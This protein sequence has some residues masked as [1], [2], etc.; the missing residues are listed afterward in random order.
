VLLALALGNKGYVGTGIGKPKQISGS[1]IPNIDTWQKKSRLQRKSAVWCC[2]CQ[3]RYEGIIG[4]G[5]DYLLYTNCRDF[6]EYNT[7]NAS[8]SGKSDFG[9]TSRYGAV[10]F[11]IDS[12]GYIG[13]GYGDG[14]YFIRFL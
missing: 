8:W 4:T 11:S 9:G 6:W 12:K 10:G 3:H 7:N 2:G 5:H 1:L 14:G 13:T